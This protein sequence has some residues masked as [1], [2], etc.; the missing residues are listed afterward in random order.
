M[1]DRKAAVGRAIGEFGLSSREDQLAEASRRL[2]SAGARR[3][4]AAPPQA[5]SVDEPT[6]GVDPKARRFRD[7]LHR[8]CALGMRCWSPRITWTRPAPPPAGLHRL[9]QAARASTAA[10]LL[11]KYGAPN[12]G[13]FIS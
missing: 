7:K 8:M 4:P 9:Q 12:L 3:L 10:E 13:R 5:P 2:N 1:A 6:A 11:A